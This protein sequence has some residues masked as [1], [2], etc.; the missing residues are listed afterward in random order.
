M[1]HEVRLAI[2]SEQ[3]YN[4]SYMFNPSSV[5][6][7]TYAQGSYGSLKSMKVQDFLVV[8][9]MYLNVLNFPE[10]VEKSIKV[11]I[12]RVLLL[13]KNSVYYLRRSNSLWDNILRRYVVSRIPAGADQ[14]GSRQPIVSRQPI[15]RL[16]AFEHT[17]HPEVDHVSALGKLRL[18]IE[19]LSC[20]AAEDGWMQTT[21]I[22]NRLRSVNF[23]LEQTAA[24]PG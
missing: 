1:Y 11:H 18:P 9:I 4:D 8:K 6:V 13:I 5:Y 10:T 17:N 7:V 16:D 24:M 3:Y 15:D 19:L 14:S 22:C 2:C 20:W 23:Y 12:K 21:T